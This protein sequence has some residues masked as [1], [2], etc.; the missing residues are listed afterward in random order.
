MKNYSYLFSLFGLSLFTLT[1]CYSSKFMVDDDVYVVKPNEIPV[2][3]SLTDETS[4]TNFKTNRSNGVSS[5]YNNDYYIINNSFNNSPFFSSMFGFSRWNNYRPNNVIFY[6]NQFG[7]SYDYW[8]SY[9]GFYDPYYSN[10]NS[11]YGFY[12]PYNGFG[13]NQNGY[14]GSSNQWGSNNNGGSGTIAHNQHNGPRGTITGGFGNS[15]RLQG[16]SKVKSTTVNTPTTVSTPNR[17]TS[18]DYLGRSTAEKPAVSPQRS[19]TSNTVGNRSDSSLEP[20]QNRTVTTVNGSVGG[21]STNSSGSGISNSGGRVNTS[22]S[23]GSEINNS[24]SSESSVG[25]SSGSSGGRS[26]GSSGGST[27]GSGGRRP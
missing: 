22:S 9:Y 13:Y 14:Y 15:N 17:V 12:S 16:D 26:T 5:T 21:R 23:S 24:R 18:S 8:D 2:G 7:F 25:S 27:S 3:E 6:S 19:S 11:Y 20:T 4:F 10:Y 1:S